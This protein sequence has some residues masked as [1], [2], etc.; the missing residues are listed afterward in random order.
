ISAL[1]SG[2]EIAFITANKLKIELD[3]KQGVFGSAI[4]GHFVKNQPMFIA[5]MLV[6]NNAVLVIFGLYIGDVF[7]F[8]L[9]QHLPSLSLWLGLYGEAMLQAILSTVIV[10]IFGEFLPKSIFS[11]SPNR[12]LNMFAVPLMIWYVLFWVFA[13][14]M[15]FLAGLVLRLMSGEKAKDE[16]YVFGRTDLD[17]YVQEAT[18]SVDRFMDMDH[19]IQIFQNALEF[20]KVKARDCMVPRNEIVAVDVREDIQ[21]LSQQFVNTRLSKILIYRDS[22]DHLIGYVHS[23]DLFNRPA[24]IQSVLRPVAIIAEPMPANEILELFIKQKKNVAVVVDEFG[25]TAGIITMEDVVEEIIGEIEDEHDGEQ[26][27]EVKISDKEF[28]FSARL[29]IDHL[30]DKYGLGLPEDEENYDTL[31]GLVLHLH[32]DIPEENYE[33]AYEGFIFKP[34]KVSETRIELIRVLIQ[35]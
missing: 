35:D 20:R 29:D 17:H 28:E 22:I 6:G 23:F 33:I 3:R 11:I 14:V 16:I 9:D 26:L 30:N 4:I 15:N 1:S 27:T 12:W 2:L 7:T 21:T 13:W 8:I 32:G 19:E 31:G 18:G 25:G 34:I 5:T 10:L 24:T